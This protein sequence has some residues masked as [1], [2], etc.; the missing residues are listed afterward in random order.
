MQIICCPNSI[1]LVD[2]GFEYDGK[3][4]IAAVNEQQI[5]DTVKAIRKAGIQNIVISGVFS[6]VNSIQEDQV[7]HYCHDVLLIP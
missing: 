5:E 3:T 1:H 4:E 7:L 6:P 2:G